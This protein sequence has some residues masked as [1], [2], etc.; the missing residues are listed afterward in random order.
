[1]NP[2]FQPGRRPDIAA[3]Q[4][5]LATAL[6]AKIAGAVA[7]GR[8]ADAALREYFRDHPECG[9]RDRRF[10]GDLVF[11]FF[12]WRGWL[13][14]ASLDQACA[15]AWAFDAESP[16]PA[17]AAMAGDAALS[18]A[19]RLALAE[20]AALAARRLNRTEPP[21]PEDLT[22]AWVPGCLACEAGPFLDAI[23]RRPPTWLRAR[24]G[25]ESAVRAALEREGIAVSAHPALHSA[26]AVPGSSPLPRLAPDVRALFE[27]QDLASQVV[28]L[29]A[30]PRPGE[31]W[32]DACAGSGGKAL[33]LADLMD[34]RGRIFASDVR[35]DALRALAR[36]AAQAGFSIIHA[37]RPG[38]ALLDGV[39][40]DAPCSGLG[41]WSRN[42][43]ARWRT[44]WADVQR[45]AARQL[46][47][48]ARASTEVKAGGRLVYSVCTLTRLETL[49]VTA[50][51]LRGHPEFRLEPGAHPVNGAETDGRFWVWPWDG[52]CDGM[53]V[54]R[55]RRG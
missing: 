18:P 19:G 1:M 11:S 32:G 38:G 49:E 45:L 46:D 34:D 48:L 21:R 52:P 9:S 14:A 30:A 3:R 20:K 36:R 50:R 33:H 40:V 39:V 42:P 53:Y 41:T 55:F 15:L 16:H 47:I 29:L 13:S 22:P 44:A 23:Q 54:A 12:R 26:L 7:R 43:D 6:V 27:V 25:Q 2:G 37:A 17:G 8:P 51:F 4:A 35:A 10:L 24:R 28:G 5:D 31:H